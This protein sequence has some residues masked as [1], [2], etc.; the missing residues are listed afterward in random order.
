MLATF[1]IFRHNPET[2]ASHYDRFQ[3]EWD[4]MERILDVL[5]RLK[6]EHDSTL[7]YPR[8]SAHGLSACARM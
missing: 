4:P 3:L 1:K 7:P 5:E 6:G 2:N 8:A